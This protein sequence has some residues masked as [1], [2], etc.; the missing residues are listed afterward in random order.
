MV[1]YAVFSQLHAENQRAASGSEPA[2][3]AEPY[4]GKITLF[5]PES[6]QRI[7]FEG[8]KEITLGRISEGQGILPDIDFSIHDGYNLGVSRLHAALK[9][10]IRGVV[11]VDL[12]SANGTRVNG[13]KISPYTFGVLRNGDEIALGKLRFKILIQ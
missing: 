4:P 11:I 6:D 8:R 1:K 5:L 13:I 2:A 9:T 3:E 7:T 12:G 10:T